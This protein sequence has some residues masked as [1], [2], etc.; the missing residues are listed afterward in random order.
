MKV[1]KT[2]RKLP[3]ATMRTGLNLLP[4]VIGYCQLAGQTL[5]QDNGETG[6]T[7]ANRGVLYTA[8]RTDSGQAFR[9]VLPEKKGCRPGSE[10]MGCPKVRRLDG[11]T[12]NE[13]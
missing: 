11:T 10:D 4:C 6:L 13:R 5:Q 2:H 1:T 3:S 8:D 12:I 7:F 9:I